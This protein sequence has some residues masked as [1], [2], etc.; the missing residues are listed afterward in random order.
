MFLQFTKPWAVL[1]RAVSSGT[2]SVIFYEITMGDILQLDPDGDDEQHDG[3]ELM[4]PDEAGTRDCAAE[5]S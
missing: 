2:C 1:S 5:E 4:T 3:D